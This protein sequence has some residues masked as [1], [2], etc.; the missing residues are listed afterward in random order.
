VRAARWPVAA[1]AIT[2]GC[3]ALLVLHAF[4][5]PGP[6]TWA[7]AHL[8]R[9]PALPVLAA[10][11]V[12]TLPP[13]VAWLWR[14]PWASAPVAVL[15]AGRVVP[16]V[17]LGTVVVT[18]L[19]LWWPVTPICIDA[20]YFAT[21]VGKGTAGSPRWYLT[22][23]TFGK[24]APLFPAFMAPLTVVRTMNCLVAAW[25]LAALAAS[26]R[27]LGRTEGEAAALTAVAWTSFGV[28]QL[29]LGYV[30]VYPTALCWTA[31]YLWA[32]SAVLL[33]DRHPLWP[34]A[35]AAAAPF[36]YVGLV[37]VAP[38]CLVVLWVVARRH[39]PRR[40]LEALAVAIVLAGL[41]TWPGYGMPFAWRAFAHELAPALAPGAPIDGRG[42]LLPTWEIASAWLWLGIAHLLVLVDG[43]G[44][45]L[46]ATCGATAIRRAPRPLVVWGVALLAPSLA[47]VVTMDPLF[48]LFADW[49]LFSYV[50]AITAMCGAYAFVVWGRR[51]PRSF[52][53]LLGLVLATALVH[54]MAR[55]NALDVDF[56]RHLAETPFR[57]PVTKPAPGDAGS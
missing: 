24:L 46:L 20:W 44:V 37:L 47:Y 31:L 14:R 50:A 49:D 48:G 12:V 6:F 7:Y 16:L 8:G 54:L 42:A 35:A 21:S 23:W 32:G 38:S 1:G 27:A 33:R 51:A 40:V 36:F 13:V 39:G 56:H 10:L 17:A 22:V 41:A 25:G 3:V 11:V 26:G 4:E 30:D 18:A 19:G 43:L 15:G 2:L 28:L 9:R 45:L 52:A 29:A 57:V 34:A 53:P 55:L 5:P